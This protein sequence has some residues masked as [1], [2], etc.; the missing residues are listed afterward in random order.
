MDGFDLVN[1][2]R[3]QDTNQAYTHLNPSIENEVQKVC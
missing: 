1:S 2:Q 3:V